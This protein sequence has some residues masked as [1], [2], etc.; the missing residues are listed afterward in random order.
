MAIGLS[1]C[2]RVGSTALLTRLGDESPGTHDMPTFTRT[3][4]TT[5]WAA[6]GD[7]GVRGPESRYSSGRRVGRAGRDVPHGVQDLMEHSDV[8]DLGCHAVAAEPVVG[9]YHIGVAAL[10]VKGGD[11]ADQRRRQRT[12][13]ACDRAASVVPNGVETLGIIESLL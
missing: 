5:N 12:P 9:A 10:Q 11:V 8:V 3:F 6:P 1:F 7:F 2:D 13:A 4:A